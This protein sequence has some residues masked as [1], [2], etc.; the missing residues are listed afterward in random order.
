MHKAVDAARLQNGTLAFGASRAEFQASAAAV[1]GCTCVNA[2]ASESTFSKEC[3]G[4]PCASTGLTHSSSPSLKFS[5][6]KRLCLKW[7][8]SVSSALRTALASK[9]YVQTRNALLFLSYNS[10]VCS[11]LA[12]ILPN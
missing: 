12:T 5:D 9:E 10:K 1:T 8:G 4:N 11:F 3:I 7:Q 6:Y 2:Q